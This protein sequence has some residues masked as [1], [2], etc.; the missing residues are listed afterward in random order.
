MLSDVIGSMSHCSWTKRH[1]EGRSWCRPL[2]SLAVTSPGSGHHW[3]GD[4]RAPSC[5]GTQSHPCQH[6]W[7]LHHWGADILTLSSRWRPSHHSVPGIPWPIFLTGCQS[8]CQIWPCL[9]PSATV[10]PSM[11]PHWRHSS[12]P[13]YWETMVFDIDGIEIAQINV[14]GSIILES[15]YIRLCI[16][17]DVLHQCHLLSIGWDWVL[18]L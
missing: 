5:L 15:V 1:I 6:T 11:R 12:L 9:C 17:T 18:P 8:P 10:L 16:S 3:H 4:P 2:C 13:P 14:V 7:H